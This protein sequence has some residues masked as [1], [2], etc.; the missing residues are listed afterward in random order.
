MIAGTLGLCLVLPA[1]ALLNGT[2]RT[3]TLINSRFQRDAQ[4]RQVLALLGEGTASFGTAANARGF[5]MVEG[6]RSR[7]SLPS[8]W[9]LNSGGQFVMSDT[10]GQGAPPAIAGDSVP[11]TTVTCTG[12]ALPLPGCTAGATL[13][14]RGWMGA[15]P[16]LLQAGRTVAVDVIVSDPFQAA[17]L[18]QPAGSASDTYRTLFNLN[19][20]ANP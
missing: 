19:V 14:T 20:E 6:I 7:Q 3:A 4:A 12:T 10:A 1:Y 16:V 9:T 18:G 15:N 13:T 11:P 17:R 2:L 5:T 8:P